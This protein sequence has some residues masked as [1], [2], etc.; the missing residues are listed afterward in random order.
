MRIDDITEILRAKKKKARKFLI[1]F[2]ISPILSMILGLF[3]PK[4]VVSKRFIRRRRG[5][6]EKENYSKGLYSYPQ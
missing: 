2:F 5:N 1:I 6:R 4:I 3:W